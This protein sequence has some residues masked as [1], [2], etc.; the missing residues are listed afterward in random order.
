MTIVVAT[1]DITPRWA[2]RVEKVK[3]LRQRRSHPYVG[4]RPRFIRVQ[5]AAFRA[6]PFCKSA[7]VAAA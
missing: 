5:R 6:P 7:I 3:R 2:Q 1:L 4:A